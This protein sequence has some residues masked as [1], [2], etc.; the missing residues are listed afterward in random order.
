MSCAVEIVRTE[1]SRWKVLFW[2]DLIDEVEIHDAARNGCYAC[3]F[4][5]GSTAVLTMAAGTPLAGLVDIFFFLM[6]GFGIR[7]LSRLA[8]VSAFV[9]YLVE[10]AVAL[11]GGQVGF[12]SFAGILAAIVL[13][14]ALRAAYAAKELGLEGNGGRI[15]HPDQLEM[16]SL[17]LWPMV[18]GAFR[19][20]L[21]GMVALMLVGWVVNRVGLLK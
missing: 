4:I 9:L 11:V 1:T 19:F 15:A 21:A 10:R 20:Y 18:R 5:C 3:L 17:K 6:A 13:F 7:Q 2:P 8:A 16:L 12:S 14:H